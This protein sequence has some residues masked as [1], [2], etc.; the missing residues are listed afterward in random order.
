MISK[1]NTTHILILIYLQ[2]WTVLKTNCLTP[3]TSSSF[4][5]FLLA[6]SCAAIS[7]SY[8]I[9]S[10]FLH[11]DLYKHA[12]LYFKMCIIGQ[13]FLF[14]KK[15]IYSTSHHKPLPDCISIEQIFLQLVCIVLFLLQNVVYRCS[16][17]AYTHRHNVRRWS[18][19]KGLGFRLRLHLQF[20]TH[21]SI[22][23][24]ALC[25]PSP[26]SFSIALHS[27]VRQIK[28]IVSH[29]KDFNTGQQKTQ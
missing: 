12:N 20:T 11:T 18:V 23:W 13:A 1:H 15:D 4:C 28:P 19:G 27:L 14:F 21:V 24:P 2:C 9:I 17:P 5:C 22:W 10:C 7:K 3:V 29:R 16:V 26:I 6:R 8:W 25:S